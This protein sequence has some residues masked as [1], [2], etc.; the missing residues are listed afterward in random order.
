MKHLTHALKEWS[1]AVDALIAGQQSILL[2]KGGIHEVGGRFTVECDRVFLYPTVEHQQPHLLKP[3][4]AKRVKSVES[5]WHPSSITL[6][7]WAH[8]TDVVALQELD[9]VMALQFMHVWNE[10]FVVE[11]LRWKPKQPL[12]VLCLRTY[13]LPNPITIPYQDSYG[14]C[15]SWIPLAEA[16]DAEAID[17]EAAQ[18][19]LTEAAYGQIV[20]AVRA[21]A[22]PPAAID[23]PLLEV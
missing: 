19:V 1:V 4:Y 17:I 18:P 9:A 22:I 7:G 16:I 10:Q 13:R 12:Y 21:L 15:R 8:I 14:G 20:A 6:Q 2:R 11:R 23:T 5:G 3:D